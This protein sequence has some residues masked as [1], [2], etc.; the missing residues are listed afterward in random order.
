M[1]HGFTRM[2]PEREGEQPTNSTQRSTGT[3]GL[4]SCRLREGIKQ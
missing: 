2:A 4:V 3:R 1:D